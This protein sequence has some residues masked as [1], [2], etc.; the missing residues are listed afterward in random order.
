MLHPHRVLEACAIA[1][2]EAF[3][4][5]FIYN[6]IH[7]MDTKVHTESLCVLNNLS[8]IDIAL[9]GAAASL[10]DFGK[11]LISDSLRKWN[12]K[13]LDKD[14]P[15]YRLI[16]FHA[17][18]G[19]DAVH[20]MAMV[21]PEFEEDF[22]KCSNVIR[23]HH[24][25]WDGMGYPARLAEDEIPL[26]SRIIAVCDAYGSMTRPERTWRA[27]LSM[28]EA[29]KEIEEHAGTQFDPLQ[30]HMFVRMM[31]NGTVEEELIKNVTI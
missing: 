31:R 13:V 24:E 26:G 19:A 8:P 9:Y 11:L 14:G 22:L 17:T 20:R 7:Q 28:E 23:H 1:V 12:S 25:R 18:I 30:A 3:R 29:L 4:G 2:A 27:P 5:S 6:H 21:F 15:E 10:H 16:R